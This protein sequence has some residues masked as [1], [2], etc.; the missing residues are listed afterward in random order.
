MFILLIAATVSVIFLGC[1]FYQTMM[2]KKMYE[3]PFCLKSE[4]IKYMAKQMDGTINLAQGLG[5]IV[6]LFTGI[7]GAYLA[8]KTYITGISNS[9]ITNHISHI[10]MFRDFVNLEV[11]KRKRISPSSVDVYVWY[12]LIFPNS[13]N[14]DLIFCSSY[15]DVVNGLKKVIDEANYHISS[16]PGDYVYK[17]HQQKMIE[18]F[19]VLGVIV[20]RGPKNS[21]LEIEAEVLEIVDSVNS[22]FISGHHLLSLIPRKYS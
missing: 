19:K 12:N 3:L 2:D 7:G 6:T 9:N 15:I 13:K 14:G 8:L 20:S 16:T 17:I 1:S 22:T 5:W 4:C 21:Y 18:A 10:N 11:A